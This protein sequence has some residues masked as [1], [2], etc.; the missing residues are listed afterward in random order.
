MVLHHWHQ[1]E[2]FD[3]LEVNHCKVIDNSYPDVRVYT[4]P[5]KEI[6]PIKLIKSYYPRCIVRTCIDL[7]IEPPEIFK[8]ICKEFD[9]L[10]EACKKN[11]PV[12][13]S[14]PQL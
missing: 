2:L 6:V 9:N 7:G 14:T 4:G 10:K 13:D 5:S 11:P 3:Y 1:E 8:K 12:S